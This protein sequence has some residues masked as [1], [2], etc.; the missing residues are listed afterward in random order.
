MYLGVMIIVLFIVG[1]IEIT[2]HIIHK[3]VDG[4]SA[5]EY[6]RRHLRQAPITFLLSFV[7]ALLSFHL[8]MIEISKLEIRNY[9]HSNCSPM[10][11]PQFRLH[12]PYRS[13]C[14]NAVAAEIYSL[15]GEAASTDYNH[16]D[17]NV[18]ARA[19]QAGYYVFDGINGTKEGPFFKV[20]NNA[21]NDSDPIV[22]KIYREKI[23]PYYN[24]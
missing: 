2:I 21:K 15:Y 13:F 8:I 11:A 3:K 7:I 22:R 10:E 23:H 20:L 4:N 12:L 9:I 17:P 16:Y 24:D 1:L 14:G 5:K 19:L 18:R 6:F